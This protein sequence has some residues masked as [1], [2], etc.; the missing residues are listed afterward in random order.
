[1]TT[2]GTLVWAWGDEM[3]WTVIPAK[4]GIQTTVLACQALLSR[5]EKQPCVYILASRRNGTLYVGVTS[6]LGQRIWHHK[7]DVVEGFTR[8]YGVHRLVWYEVHSTMY[9]AIAREKA[10]KKWNREWKMRLIE[11]SNPEWADLY[12][13][14]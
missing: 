7:E 11:E 2:S 14:L 8:R 5:M 13:S 6:A 1:V 4:A 10:I 3:P 9:A 12:T